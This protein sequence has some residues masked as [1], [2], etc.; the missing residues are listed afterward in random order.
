MQEHI[1]VLVQPPGGL[2]DAGKHLHRARAVPTVLVG[3]ILLGHLLCLLSWG[4]PSCTQA[5]TASRGTGETAPGS[6]LIG[7]PVLRTSGVG[8]LKSA[9]PDIGV[10]GL[11]MDDE[12]DSGPV[13][14]N[15]TVFARHA[16]LVAVL[17]VTPS[18][19]VVI[20][21][22]A[23]DGQKVGGTSSVARRRVPSPVTSAAVRRVY[24]AS[25]AASGRLAAR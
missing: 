4:S 8:A 14:E 3:W 7:C 20:G 5:L 24:R 18:H 25:G 2:L 23:E 22:G 21:D 6:R 17:L 11:V 12:G 10:L 13:G 19:E 1:R 15:L 9:Q 16:V